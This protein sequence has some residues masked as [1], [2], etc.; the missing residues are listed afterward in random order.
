MTLQSIQ[1]IPAD[2]LQAAEA[3]LKEHKGRAAVIAGGTD[4]IGV[5]KDAIHTDPP[6]VLIGLKPAAGSGEVSVEPAGVRIGALT[7]LDYL[8]RHP[9]IRQSYPLLAQAAASVASPQIRNGQHRRNLCRSRAAGT[10]ATSITPSTACA[11]AALVRRHVRREPL[12]FHLRRHY[13]SGRTVRGCNCPI[14]TISPPMA[15]LREG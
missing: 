10:T 2:S 3:L 11:R 6:E 15:K 9:A 4:L 13:A 1:Y 7:T 14:T 8:A 5:L 12:P